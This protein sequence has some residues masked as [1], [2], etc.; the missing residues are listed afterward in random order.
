MDAGKVEAQAADEPASRAYHRSFGMRIAQLRKDRAM[1]QAELASRL[2][3][4]QQTVFAYEAGERR[5]RINFL[6]MLT[7]IFRISADEL[8][9]ITQPKQRPQDCV[10]ARLAHHVDTLQRLSAADSRFVIRLA[11]AMALRGS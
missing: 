11:Q 3:V 9:G 4:S 8:L 6:P 2:G 1:T 10:S 5:V 7:E